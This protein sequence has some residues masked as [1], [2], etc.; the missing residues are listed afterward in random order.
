MNAWKPARA[1]PQ[2]A[3]AQILK[4]LEHTAAD[5][6][7]G[8]THGGKR[9]AADSRQVGIVSHAPFNRRFADVS[10]KYSLRRIPDA[11]GASRH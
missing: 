10:W 9:H 7:S 5:Q 4:L 1:S 8:V 11:P 3:V 2:Y 6:R